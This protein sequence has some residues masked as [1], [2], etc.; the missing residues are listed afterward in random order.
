MSKIKTHSGWSRLVED[1]QDLVP[2]LHRDPIA[3]S[4]VYQ[5]TRDKIRATYVKHELSRP[6][7]VSSSYFASLLP[8]QSLSNQS[9][10]SFEKFQSS[11]HEKIIT[12]AILIRTRNE[13][14][15]NGIIWPK[16]GQISFVL[17]STD[18]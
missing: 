14:T 18:Q 3:V 4:M 5:N 1:A 2:R 17:S 16:R 8:F 15:P 7:A 10:R 12:H 11:K 9:N 6:V 13:Q